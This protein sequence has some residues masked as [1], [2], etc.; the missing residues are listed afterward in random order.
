MTDP[1][2]ITAADQLGRRRVRMLPVLAIFFLLQQ[3]SF[4][5][6]PP[7]ERVVDHV[8]I[9]SWVLLTGVILMLLQTGGMWL[10]PAAVRAMMNDGPTQ[11]NRA[12]AGHW[13]FVAMALSGM[14]MYSIL[15]VAP[16]TARQAIHLV[17][18]AGIVVALLRFAFLERRTY[19]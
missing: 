13:G 15:G 7:G 11:A 1:S 19:E 10:R 18:S 8:R 5:A 4:F 3:V 16:M 14:T 6:D 2:A 9:F 17:V 12:S